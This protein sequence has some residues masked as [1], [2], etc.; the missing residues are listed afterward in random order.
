MKQFR[1]LVLALLGLLFAAS[2]LAQPAQRRAKPQQQQQGTSESVIF[3]WI[4]SD[5]IIYIVSEKPSWW[6]DEYDLAEDWRTIK[7]DLPES[8][9]EEGLPEDNAEEQD[10]TDAATEGGDTTL[11]DL[12]ARADRL[13]ETSQVSEPPSNE[14]TAPD[15]PPGAGMQYIGNS[16]TKVFHKRDCR[17]IYRKNRADTY[18]I[19]EE[20]RIFFTSREDAVDRKYRP[21][22]FC[23]P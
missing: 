18:L 2:V 16:R 9:P 10:T 1:V 3:K 17:L 13:T 20:N 7:P 6:K 4:D 21:C 12:I 11:D 14:Q 19:P 15:S 5:G 22:Q 8:T 23:K